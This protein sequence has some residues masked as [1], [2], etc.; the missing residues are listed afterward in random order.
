MD[1]SNILEMLGILGGLLRIMEHA[2]EFL[3][4]WI[5]GMYG[6]SGSSGDRPRRKASAA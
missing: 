1:P 6:S 5:G 3:I 4:K 2:V